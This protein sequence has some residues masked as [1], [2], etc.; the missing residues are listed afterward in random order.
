MLREISNSQDNIREQANIEAKT[1][2]IRS[3]DNYYLV[4][5]PNQLQ[6]VLDKTSLGKALASRQEVNQVLKKIIKSY[7]STIDSNEEYNQ[8]DFHDCIEDITKYLNALTSLLKKRQINQIVNKC[9]E[10]LE[11]DVTKEKNIFDEIERQLNNVSL[12]RQK[13][14]Q[15][16]KHA[17]LN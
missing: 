6:K 9:E 7:S 14:E 2:K 5:N 16:K 12:S 4:K 1:L 13:I 15:S 8:K 10:A 17:T 11:N 3:N